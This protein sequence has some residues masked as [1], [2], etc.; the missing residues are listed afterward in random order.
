[1][2]LEKYGKSTNKYQKTLI[3]SSIVDEVRELSP[4]GGFV[5]KQEPNGLW[6]EVG[7]HL[8]REKAG[9]N[10]R[11][12]LSRQYKSSTKAKRRRR[13]VVGTDLV[14]DV[15]NMIQSNSFVS[16]QLND[17]QNHV[18]DNGD[19]A[20]EVFMS[21]MFTQ[22]NH[23]ILE[24]FKQDLTLHEEFQKAEERRKEAPTLV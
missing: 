18:K 8:A 19:T 3:V 9:Q 7:D 12:G 5:K 10:L 15:E 13:N 23:A 4:E 20:P 17:L 21:N 22:T 16:K 2:A 1:M 14:Y 6:Y 11:D 24:A